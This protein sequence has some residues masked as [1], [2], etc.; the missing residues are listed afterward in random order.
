MKGNLYELTGNTQ[1]NRDGKLIYYDKYQVVE[2]NENNVQEKRLID[3]KTSGVPLQTEEERK[4]AEARH[5][6]YVK[7]RDEAFADEAELVAARRWSENEL[8]Q[9]YRNRKR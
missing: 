1:L 9:N 4:R 6:D 7:R 8:L 2:L 3:N 5:K